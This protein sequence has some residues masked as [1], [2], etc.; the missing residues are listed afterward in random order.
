AGGS[1]AV[2]FFGDAV[3]V[4]PE[5]E[6]APERTDGAAPPEVD[7]ADP[8]AD[9]GLPDQAPARKRAPT[10]PTP[11]TLVAA[12]AAEAVKPFDTAAY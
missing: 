3:P 10:E 4:D 1:D 7:E 6:A 5:T 9:L 12:R 8:F 2:P 11:A